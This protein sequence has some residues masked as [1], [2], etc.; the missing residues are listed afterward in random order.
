MKSALAIGLSSRFA[1]ANRDGNVE[2]GGFASR[3]EMERI[4]LQKTDG[5]SVSACLVPYCSGI[6]H[7]TL[8]SLRLKR[9]L[10]HR[11]QPIST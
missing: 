4:S 2:S 3:G 11:F 10:F 5:N 6:K 1:L 9:E 7:N 8:V